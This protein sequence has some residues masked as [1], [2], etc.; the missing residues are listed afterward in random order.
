MPPRKSVRRSLRKQKQSKRRT[1]R[2]TNRKTMRRKNKYRKS[3]RGGTLSNEEKQQIKEGLEN[4]PLYTTYDFLENMEPQISD[5]KFK[6]IRRE[7]ENKLRTD[8]K[9]SRKTFAQENFS[10]LERKRLCS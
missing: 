7:I 2:K 10:K 3:Q 9:I 1:T 8:I 4:N 6:E 5:D